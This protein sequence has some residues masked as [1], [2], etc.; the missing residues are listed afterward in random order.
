MVNR[1]ILW[2]VDPKTPFPI[3]KEG[4]HSVFWKLSKEGCDT[5]PVII[6]GGMVTLFNPGLQTTPFAV[7]PELALCQTIATI[8]RVYLGP[9]KISTISVERST[10][11]L[12]A[13]DAIIVW[14][15]ERF[16]RYIWSLFRSFLLWLGET[17][18]SPPL[19]LFGIF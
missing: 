16:I 2:I 14:N 13:K 6:R 4:V 17:T 11:C 12:I 5:A 19:P 10:S 15:S 1:Q 9:S 18:P 3:Y 8:C 7:G